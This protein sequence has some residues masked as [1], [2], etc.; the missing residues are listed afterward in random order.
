MKELFKLKIIFSYLFF[1]ENF[2]IFWFTWS[3]P[4]LFFILLQSFK[5]KLKLGRKIWL[6]LEKRQISTNGRWSVPLMIGQPLNTWGD[7]SLDHFSRRWVICLFWPSE[8]LQEVSTSTRQS[9]ITINNKVRCP[10]TTVPMQHMYSKF[11]VSLQM[12]RLFAGKSLL[13][14]DD[15]F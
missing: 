5:R 7:W 15:Y 8:L 4:K 13:F 2:T 1:F 14:G 3:W 9:W 11:I 12:M 10:F 6:S